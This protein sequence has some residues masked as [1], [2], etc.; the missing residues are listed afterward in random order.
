MENTATKYPLT[1]P[2]GWMRS[3]TKDRA[4]FKTSFTRARDAL[5]HEISLLGGESVILSSNLPLR[6][7]G[8]PRADFRMPTDPGVAV[9]FKYKG[10]MMCFACDKWERVE[11]NVQSICLSIGAIRGLERWGASDMI[12]RAFTGFTALPA[13]ASAAKAWH[14]VLNVRPDASIDDIKTARNRLVRKYHPDMGDEPSVDMTAKINMAYEEGCR[15]RMGTV[16]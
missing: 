12:E 16:R 6:N 13:P 1:W 15:E 4:R 2:Q 10:K 11:D 9:Y 7:D 14:E 3:P 5:L 8:L